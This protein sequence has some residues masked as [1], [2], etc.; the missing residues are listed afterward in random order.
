MELTIEPAPGG[1]TTMTMREDAVTGP[2]SW[3]P[4]AARQAALVVRNREALHR[5]SLLA[6]R[7]TD[8]SKG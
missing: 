2:V 8:D 6:E 3:V 5:L 4:R 1:G 7:N